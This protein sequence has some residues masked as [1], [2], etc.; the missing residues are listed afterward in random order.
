MYNYD[1]YSN[2]N[3]YNPSGYNDERFFGIPFII[4]GLAGGAL[5]YGIGAY[6][7]NQGNTYYPVYPV[8][9]PTYYNPVYT[10][11]PTYPTYQTSNNYYY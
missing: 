11:Y 7:N 4:G 1:N 8:T 10:T 3:N 6:Q 2:F 9:Y 5:G